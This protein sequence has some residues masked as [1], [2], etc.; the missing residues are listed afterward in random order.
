MLRRALHLATPLDLRSTLAPLRHGVGDP[1]IRLLPQEA[2]RATRTPD[3]PATVHLAVHGDRLEVEAWGE[4]A[5]RALHELPVLVGELDDPAGLRPRHRLIARLHRDHPGLRIP[6]T[7]RL[8]EALLPAVLEQRVTGFEAKRAYHQLIARW[9]EPAPGPPGL[10][11]APAPEVLADVPYYDLHV[12]GVEKKRA[13]VLRR[14]GAHA[15]RLEPLAELPSLEAQARL[16]AIPGIG[17]WTAAEVAL[18]ALGD[19]DAVSVGDYHLKHQV[20]YALAG[21]ERGTDARMLELLEP[22][23]G[24]RGRV[25]RLIVAAGITAPRRAPRYTPQPIASM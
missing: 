11:L 23:A 5:E 20:A 14:V 15:A 25:C 24:H 12:L 7:G 17:V 6:R 19:A 13:D 16:R 22:Y 1:T 9:G 10:L 3:G 4:G 2:W 18:V 8:F 21:E